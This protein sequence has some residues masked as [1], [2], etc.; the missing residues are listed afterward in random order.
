MTTPAIDTSVLMTRA[1]LSDDMDTFRQ[2]NAGLDDDGVRA[3]AALLGAVFF[4]AAND[5]FGK[6]YAVADV[7]EFVAEARA[8]HVGPETVSAEDAEHVIRAVLGEEGL[9][10]NMSAYARGEARTAMLIAIVRDSGFSDDQIDALLAVAA[11]QVR[12]FFGRQGRQ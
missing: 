7:I 8:R 9:V 5:K 1:L 11:Q 4:K 12:S 2:L 6:D 3:F 10:G